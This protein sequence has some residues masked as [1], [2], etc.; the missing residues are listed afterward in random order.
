MVQQC[1]VSPAEGDVWPGEMDLAALSPD[2]W[3]PGCAMEKQR[4]VRGGGGAESAKEL[5]P[6][7]K[8]IY[9]HYM[10]LQQ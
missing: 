2:R 7:P 10:P 9:S 1:N 5:P 8:Y 4:R 3:P 6:R